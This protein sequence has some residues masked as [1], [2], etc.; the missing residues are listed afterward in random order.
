VRKTMFVL[1]WIALWPVALI[2]AL[3]GAVYHALRAGLAAYDS[4]QYWVDD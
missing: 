2:G 1:W 4:F 3:A